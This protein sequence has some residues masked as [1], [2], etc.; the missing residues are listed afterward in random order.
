MQ[1]TPLGTN[2]FFPSF[3]RQTMSFLLRWEG[4]ALLLDAG[5]GLGRLM[6]PGPQAA[7]RSA[8]RL[9]V[10]LTHYHLDH[11]IGLPSLAATWDAGPITLYV[12]APPLVDGEPEVAMDHLFGRPLFPKPLSEFPVPVDLRPY[13]DET[14]TA[15]GLTLRT[16]RQTH[17]GG[18]VGLRIGDGI[19]YCTD[20]VADP[21]T[22]RLARGVDLLMHEVW[23]TD[24]EATTTDPAPAGHSYARQVARI[25]EQA[26]VQRLAPVH[27]HPKRDG[28]G[29]EELVRDLEADG[30][31]PVILLR[32][33][34][35][36][37]IV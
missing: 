10:V 25:A 12:P 15:A 27:H 18:S 11:V 4:E 32:E 23:L 31:T 1:L 26:A 6:E 33:G 3:D 35:S 8:E 37:G 9:T 29:L 16:R 20:T 36:Y 28:A 7:L 30:S 2:G 22:A 34:T 13:A 14:L 17:P 19:A 5:S 21:E 24:D